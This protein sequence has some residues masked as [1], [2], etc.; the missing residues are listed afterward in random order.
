LTS[1]RLNFTKSYGSSQLDGYDCL[2]LLNDFSKTAV[3]AETL[4]FVLVVDDCPRS[5]WEDVKDREHEMAPADMPTNFELQ[6]A[7]CT[8]HVILCGHYLES[9]KNKVYYL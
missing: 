1:V 9:Y 3:A 7:S 6:Y 5:I 4:Y 8:F 2:K